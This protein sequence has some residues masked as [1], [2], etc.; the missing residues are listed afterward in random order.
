MHRPI[1]T[2]LAA[3]V[4][5]GA[6]VPAGVAAAALALPAANASVGTVTAE[7][8][9]DVTVTHDPAHYP[10]G[11]YSAKHDRAKARGTVQ[12]EEAKNGSYKI[13]VKGELWDLDHHPRKCAYVEFKVQR[14]G[15]PHGKWYD[16]RSYKWCHYGKHPK[17]F[18]FWK[19]DVSAVKVRVSQ[20][21]KHGHHV[22]NKGEWHSIPEA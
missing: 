18:A 19:T 16:A 22:F 10:W 3:A 8:A 17:E 14:I 20:I 12:L 2:L 13:R 5:V 9:P 11:P 15:A 21:G 6:A 4:A 7:P 1:R